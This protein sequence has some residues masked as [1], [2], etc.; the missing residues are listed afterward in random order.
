MLRDRS[1]DGS[2]SPLLAAV[3]QLQF[4]VSEGIRMRGMQILWAV[5]ALNV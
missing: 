2:G 4:E 5:H 1:D 3:G